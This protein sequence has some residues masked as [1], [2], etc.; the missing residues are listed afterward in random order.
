MVL[1][2]E[3]AV[4]FDIVGYKYLVRN[5]AFQEILCVAFQSLT[6]AVSVTHCGFVITFSGLGYAYSFTSECLIQ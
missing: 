5:K 3:D 6:A 2:T 1:L 4:N